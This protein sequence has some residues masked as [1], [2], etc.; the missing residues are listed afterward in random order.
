MCKICKRLI[1]PRECPNFEVG[2]PSETNVICVLCGDRMVEG[3]RYYEM[4]GF[5]YCERCLLNADGYSLIRICEKTEPVFFE[6]IGF[7]VKT[8]E[9][10]T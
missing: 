8:A 7:S 4:H 10:E 3:T 9:E 5:P 6:K 2:E 1:C